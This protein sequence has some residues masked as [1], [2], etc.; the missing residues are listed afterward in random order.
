MIFL[1]NK[2]VIQSE[3]L[4]KK[5]I[6]QILFINQFLVDINQITNHI[7]SS[8]Y[9]VKRKKNKKKSNHDSTREEINHLYIA[10]DH[11]AVIVGGISLMEQFISN[12][13]QL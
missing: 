10:C 6:Y 11:H 13:G 2:N 5:G 4:L 1:N 3:G 8:L 12:Y 7:L 9:V